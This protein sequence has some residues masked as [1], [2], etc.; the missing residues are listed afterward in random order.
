MTDTQGLLLLTSVTTANQHDGWIASFLV[1]IVKALFPKIAL[2][3]ADKGYRGLFV[4]SA[5]SLRINV[6]IIGQLAGQK[7]FV[8]QPR[9]WVVERTFAW[10]HN[11]RRLSKDYEEDT[12][13]AEAMIY[14]AMSHLMVRRLARLKAT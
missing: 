8:V 6:A 7:G 3:W 5:L 12:E 11:Y 4:E 9:R 14:A 1:L 2:I 13:S 10:L